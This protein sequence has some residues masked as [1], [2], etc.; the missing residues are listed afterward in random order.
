MGTELANE[1]KGLAVTEE[2]VCGGSERKKS[3]CTEMPMKIGLPG[4]G[5][6]GSERNPVNRGVEMEGQPDQRPLPGPQLMR[7]PERTVMGRLG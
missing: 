2:R 5:T 4:C 3:G 7:K 1:M 6:V